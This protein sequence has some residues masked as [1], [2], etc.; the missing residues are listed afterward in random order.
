WSPLL[1]QFKNCFIC[2]MFSHLLKPPHSNLF[3]FL[4]A[5][6][7][8]LVVIVLVSFVELD[9]SVS[10]IHLTIFAQ[11]EGIFFRVIL[12]RKVMSFQTNETSLN[13]LVV[14]LPQSLHKN[15][16]FPQ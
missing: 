14:G 3:P 2:Q 9:E 15:D 13:K 7:F 11:K 12:D 16:R 5:Q 1:H 10:Y 6:F 4:I 8:R